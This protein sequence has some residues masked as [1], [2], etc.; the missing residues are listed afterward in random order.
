M[1][2][3]DDAFTDGDE[4]G[5]G[6]RAALKFVAWGGVAASAI[7]IAV[8][9]A[10][11]DTGTQRLA[12]IF[13]GPAPAAADSIA[14]QK[15]NPLAARLADTE[16]E[17]ARLN[18]TVRRLTADRDRVVA[19]LDALER[20]LDVTASIR[21]RP[22][23][24]AATPLASP[25]PASAAAPVPTV[26]ASAPPAPPASEPA[27]AAS[28]LAPSP[29][30]PPAAAN[31]PPPASVATHPVPR[32]ATL[33]LPRVVTP[34]TAEQP[35]PGAIPNTAIESTATR[36]EFGVDVGGDRT[37]DALR[38][39]WASLRAGRHGALFEGMRPV[40]SVREG[41]KP[42]GIELRLVVG[43]LVNAAAAAKLCG[44]LAAR[45]LAC[46][47]TVFDG[48]RLALR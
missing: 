36:T 21:D 46:Q 29:V 22:P 47:P 35:R 33:P 27:P 14:S 45:G 44:V 38:A 18:E 26:V 15:A 31:P 41:G 25:P 12:R 24:P 43:P 32:E 6:L 8:L 20:N 7:A 11:T 48:Q 17:A 19:R 28:I 34:P 16:A 2:R 10:R 9:S 5:A 13:S 40:V 23:A 30:M 37:V 4:G 1:A 3:D 39:L 42:A